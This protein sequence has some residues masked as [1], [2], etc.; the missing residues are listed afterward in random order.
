VLA[1]AGAAG[2]K[3]K[4][5]DAPAQQATVPSPHGS[6]AEPRLP[7]PAP[8]PDPAA[9]AELERRGVAAIQQLG[10]TLAGDANDC[11]RIA[12]DLRTFVA[13]NKPLLAQLAA[14]QQ[15][16]TDNPRSAAV[17]SGAS[18]SA[19]Q[20]LQ[21]AIAICASNPGVVAVMKEFPAD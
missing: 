20:K 8:A 21:Q 11:E 12:A 7:D 16:D 5:A 3:A 9:A 1:A 13:G 15:R 17:R 4:R 19:G 14:A 2:C 6:T 18:A 10:D